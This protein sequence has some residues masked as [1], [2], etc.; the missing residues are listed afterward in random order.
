MNK[1][2]V[3]LG[4]THRSHTNWYPWN[5]FIHTF[6]ELGLD[7][8]WTEVSN[9]KREKNKSYVFVCW[10]TPDVLEMI[11]KGMLTKEDVIYQ[12]VTSMTG[13]D[14]NVNWG[15]NPHEFY[16]NWKWPAY[17]MCVDVLKQ[18]YNLYAFG[19]RTSY[20]EYSIKKQLVNELGKRLIMIPWTTC[21]YSYDELQKQKPIITNFEYDSCFVGSI[22]GK[23]GRG[24][25][26]SV[27]RYLQPVLSESEKI[28][29]AGMG[30]QNGPISNEEHISFIKK[31]KLCPIIN[32]SSW[33]A[34][35]GVQDRF[36]TVFASGRFGVVDTEG[37]YDFYNKDEVVCATDP[38]EY[39][40]K[41]LY[42]MKNID[43]QIPFIEKIQKR[44][45][46]EYNWN[47]NFKKIFKDIFYEN[48]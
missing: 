35:R 19:C 8:V 25:I 27:Q 47:N 45:K 38:E 18:G 46:E 17:Q 48:S 4:Y 42:Y 44:I 13:R 28:Y 3:L 16:K 9:F 29:L 2:V 36:W 12:K 43:K 31:S 37:V 30:T 1:Q 32:A 6:R 34:E 10:N 41:S 23:V 22:W 24:N 26:D 21:M 11:Q 5:R 14:S 39:I 40:D 20:E 33:R 7:C 15:E